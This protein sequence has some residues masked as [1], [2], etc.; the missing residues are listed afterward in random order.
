[1]S[2]KDKIVI[3]TGGAKG[4]GA[5]CAKVFHREQGQVVVWDPDEAAA[6][7]LTDRLGEGATFIS[8]DVSREEEVEKAIAQTTDKVG[9]PDVLVNN[10]GILRYAKVTET[11]EEEWD[12]IMGVNVKGAFLCAK[13]T[14]PLMQEKGAG[15]VVNMSSVQAFISQE[16]V[17]AY[18]TSKSALIGLTRSIAVDYAPDIR[19]VA[20]CPGGVDTPL[21]REAFRQSPDPEKARQETVNLH[22]LE[23]MA[24]PEEIGELVAFVSGE[25]GS[26]INGQP[27][28]IDGGLGSFI[29]GGKRD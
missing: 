20:I 17:A 14:I 28:R 26:F 13:H 25:K 10:A 2:F 7:Q 6:K 15:V 22:L 18:V 19:S 12:T 9:T 29:A 11:T 8:C 16:N 21:N 27:I 24:T 4:I 5:G 23:R 1:M 3:I